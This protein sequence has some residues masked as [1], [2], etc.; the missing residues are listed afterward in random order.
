MVYYG[1]RKEWR[2]SIVI[3]ASLLNPF[4]NSGFVPL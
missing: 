4:M 1:N 2:W 3:V